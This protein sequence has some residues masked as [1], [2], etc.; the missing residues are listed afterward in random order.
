MHGSSVFAM[1]MVSSKMTGF[2]GV[3]GDRSKLMSLR[4][5]TGWSRIPVVEESVNMLETTSSGE[6]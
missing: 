6:D 2:R 3:G 1:P 5:P 4:S